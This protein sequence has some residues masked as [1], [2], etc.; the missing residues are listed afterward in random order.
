MA[1]TP[2]T[3][4]DRDRGRDGTKKSDG[5]RAMSACSTVPAPGPTTAVITVK[6]GSDRTGIT[7]VTNLAGV[8]LLL[9]TGGAGGPSGTR[10]DGVAGTGDG[11]AH[12]HLGRRRRL[13]LHRS[14]HA[15][16]PGQPGGREPRRAVLGHPVERS[17]PATTRTR[18]SAPAG[19][20]GAGTA[21]PYRFRTGTQLRANTVY[22]SQ[23]ANDF[24]LSSGADR[25]TAS[26]GI[27]QQSRINPA[28][29]RPRAVSTSR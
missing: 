24:M 20:T 25:L 19:P 8:V 17:R 29:C 7:G 13:L 2:T 5:A 10:P 28:L 11:W 1:A 18:A 9:N 3:H 14:E 6:V 4:A 12:V 27:W 21:T 15:G 22:S 26:G 23:N 16:R